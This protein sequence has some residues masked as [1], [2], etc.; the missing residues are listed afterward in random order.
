MKQWVSISLTESLHEK[1]GLHGFS[2]QQQ[3]G[4]HSCLECGDCHSKE[5]N[6]YC[7]H[8]LGEPEMVDAVK[9]AQP[10]AQ[11]RNHIFLGPLDF[12]PCT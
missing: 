9:Y 12:I 1:P 5:L 8:C 2:K 7:C 3:S 10:N 6:T 11:L 4:R